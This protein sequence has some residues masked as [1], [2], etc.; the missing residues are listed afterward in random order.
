M[1]PTRSEEPRVGGRRPPLASGQNGTA[2]A[3]TDPRAVDRTWRRRRAGTLL[4][5]TSVL[6][7]HEWLAP[8]LVAAW[9]VWLILHRRLEGDL[10]TAV[11]RGW[12]RAWPP[13]GLLL[14][15]LLGANAFAYWAYA[16]VPGNIVPIALNLLGLSI[17]LFGDWWA[18]RI[19]PA[20]L[21]LAPGP[22]PSRAQ[23]HP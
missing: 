7:L 17:V 19:W 13:G 5:V 11:V 20:R 4:L 23:T 12:R 22:A 6:W 16:P 15:A 10:G 8:L 3:Q 1:S 2:V 18:L 9:V 21:T 14:I